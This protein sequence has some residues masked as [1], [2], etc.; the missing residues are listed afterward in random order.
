[1]A[2]EERNGNRYYYHKRRIGD[3]VVSEYMGGGELAEAFA[4]LDGIDRQRDD[5]EREATRAEQ[6]AQRE[7]DKQIDEMIS[8]ARTLADATLL[9]AGYHRHKGQ[10]RK[11]RE[12]HTDDS[13]RDQGPGQ[14]S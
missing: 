2:W 3:R 10:W 6:E 4:Y 14:E 13:G 12:R 7:I 5:L 9:A 11:R 8:L 1:M